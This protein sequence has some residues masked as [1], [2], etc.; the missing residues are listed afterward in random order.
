M[1]SRALLTWGLLGLA[2]LP[3]QGGQLTGRPVAPAVP[4]PPAPAATCGSF[5]TSVEFEESPAAAAKRAAKEEK[6]VFILHVSGQFE[7]PGIT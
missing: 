5:G 6:L 1:R 3:A 7:D 4:E 2:L